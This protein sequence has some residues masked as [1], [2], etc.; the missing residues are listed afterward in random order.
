M[1]TKRFTYMKIIEYHSPEYH[2]MLALRYKIL[3]AP[4]GLVFSQENLQQEKDD[5]FI[6]CCEDG[7]IVGCCILTRLTDKEIKLRQM[8]VDNHWQGKDIGK[9]ILL[10]AEQYAVGHGFATIKLHARKTAVGFY[11]KSGY[12][13]SGDEFLELGIPHFLMFKSL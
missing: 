13:V 8:A 6:V 10:F 5:V 1:L 3:R 4:L 7:N 11:S 12:T 2:E 9:K